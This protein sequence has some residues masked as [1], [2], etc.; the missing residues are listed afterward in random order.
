MLHLA[1][2]GDPIAHSLSPRLHAAALEAAGIAGSY[3]ARRVDSAGVEG[4]VEE[5]REGLL[6]GANVTMP[7]KELAAYLADELSEVARRSRSVNTLSIRDGRVFGETTDVGG[8]RRAWGPLPSGVALILGAGGAAAAALLALEGRQLFVASR[9]ADAAA[10]LVDRTGV[11]AIA[12][13]WGRPVAGA[14]VVNATPLGMAGEH[15]PPG[16]VESAVGL[17][18][19]V[20]GAV[21]TPA[22]ELAGSL[23]LTTVAGLEML[24]AQAAASFEIWT[25]ESPSVDAMRGAVQP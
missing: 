15:L 16:I 2:L 10:A 5:M 3:E 22:V 17:F 9:Q 14:V 4:A 20:Y 24:I 6:D 7:H 1:L 8:I 19:M 21:P 18:D 13:P 11:A 12:V 25:G 23:G